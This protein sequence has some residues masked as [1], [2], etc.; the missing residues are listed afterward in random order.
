MVLLDLQSCV[1]D[2]QADKLQGMLCQV[3]QYCPPESVLRG[4]MNILLCRQPKNGS[5]VSAAGL[6]LATVSD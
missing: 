6:N 1:E 2:K 4:R 3:V 5:Y